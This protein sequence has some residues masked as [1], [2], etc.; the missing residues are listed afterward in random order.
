[1][2]PWYI[3]MGKVPVEYDY[4]TRATIHDCTSG[5]DFCDVWI[6]DRVVCIIIFVFNFCFNSALF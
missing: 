1:M 3:E 4:K 6:R 2:F 5:Q